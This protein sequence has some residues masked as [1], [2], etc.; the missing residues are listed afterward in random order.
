MLEFIDSRSTV[1]TIELDAQHHLQAFY[2]KHGFNVDGI[3]Y[4]DGG[5]LH[6]RMIR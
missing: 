6:I 2:E 3:P 1:S 5:I 4:D